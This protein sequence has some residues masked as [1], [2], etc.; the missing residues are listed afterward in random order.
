MDNY[1]YRIQHIQ[2]RTDFDCGPAAIKMLARLFQQFPSWS[3]LDFYSGVN[4]INGTSFRGMYRAL[5]AVS[6]TFKKINNFNELPLKI[7]YPILTLIPDKNDP[8]IAHYVIVTHLTQNYVFLHDS[9][10]GPHRIKRK[11]FV[12]LLT[13]TGNWYGFIHP[14]NKLVPI[15]KTYRLQKKDL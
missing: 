4:P 8:T 7:P 10:Y 9:Y 13:K 2:Q 15:K 3:F 1:F 5:R 11:E 14:I 12:K 6:L